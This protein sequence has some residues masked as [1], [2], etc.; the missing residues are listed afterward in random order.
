MLHTPSHFDA[1]YSGTDDPWHLRTRWYEQRKRALTLACLPAARFA[2]AYEPG[3]AGGELS[4]A[5]ASRC[6]RLLISD[7][8]VN[9]LAVARQRTAGFA[10]VQACLAQLPHGWPDQRFDLIV[11]SEVAYYLDAASLDQLAERMSDSLLPQGTLLAC[12]WRA[13]IAGC[14]MTGDDV[15]RRLA[16]GLSMTALCSYRDDDLRLDVWSHG[17]Q[18]VAEREGFKTPGKL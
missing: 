14:A 17:S 13:P 3:C 15:H 5:L 9:A 16:H 1:M 10:H 11:L 12:H 4:L 18:S 2:S 6:D 8:S 7:A